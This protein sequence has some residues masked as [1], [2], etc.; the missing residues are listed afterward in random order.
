[1]TVKERYHTTWYEKR[2]KQNQNIKNFLINK[3]LEH[4][5]SELMW[6][7]DQL[8]YLNYED[9]FEIAVAAVNK[10]VS[11]TLGEGS[12]VSNGKDCKVSVVRSNSRG[13][14]YSALITGCKNKK[15]VLAFVYEGIQ[16]K[17]YFFSFP[18]TLAEHTIPFDK[19]NGDPKKYAH[20][21]RPTPMWKWECKTFEQM[22]LS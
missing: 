16:E 4:K 17:F 14:A 20:G 18:V 19:E 15:H 10:T 2:I 3:I 8:G 11:I 5:E 1:M 22:A 21:W 6:T 9:L 13:A 7:R 12:D